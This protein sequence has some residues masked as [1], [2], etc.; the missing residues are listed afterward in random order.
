[1][2]R[3]PRH[4]VFL[5]ADL[6]A[7]IDA[8]RD[9]RTR[10]EEIRRRLEWSLSLSVGYAQTPVKDATW[11]RDIVTLATPG[12]QFGPAVAPED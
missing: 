6:V 2:S 5:P 4:H 8:V 10:T 7:R 9:G 11:L 1:M 12:E 3:T